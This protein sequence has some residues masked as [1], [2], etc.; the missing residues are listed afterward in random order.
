[1]HQ[2]RPAD[3]AL[4]VISVQRLAKRAAKCACVPYQVVKG[5]LGHSM[6]IGAAQAMMVAALA[7]SPS[8]RLAAGR[9][10]T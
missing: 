9:P 3:A 10:R 1:V 2:A 5:L 8:G 7:A 4:N 6:G